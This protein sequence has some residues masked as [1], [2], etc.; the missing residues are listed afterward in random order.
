MGNAL[1]GHRSSWRVCRI[2]N[3]PTCRAGS[4]FLTAMPRLI[5]PLLTLLLLCCPVSAT[6]TEVPKTARQQTPQNVCFK[7]GRWF[8]GKTFRRRM[9]C[10]VGGI[11]SDRKPEHIDLIVDLHGRFVVPP[12]WRCS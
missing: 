2:Y 5:T 4:V 11:L 1:G 9:Y 3:I 12:L 10:S 6:A 7:H 8:D